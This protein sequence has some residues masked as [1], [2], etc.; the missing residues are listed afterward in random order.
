MHNYNS[1]LIIK[2]TYNYFW[3]PARSMMHALAGRAQQQQQP[4]QCFPCCLTCRAATD[5]PFGRASSHWCAFSIPINAIVRARLGKKSKIAFANDDALP[6]HHATLLT[7]LFFLLL[8][9]QSSYRLAVWTCKFALVRLFHPNQ[10]H[11]AGAPWEK[12][13]N[14]ICE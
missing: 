14:R 13:E 3:R 6:S 9:L 11:C 12:V 7:T 10:C 5:S 1:I 2:Y 8:D 4:L